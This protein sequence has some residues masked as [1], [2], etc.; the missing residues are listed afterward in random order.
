[1]I[2]FYLLSLMAAIGC[3]VLIDRRYKLAFFYD[4]RCTAYTLGTSIV[5]FIVWDLLGIHLDIFYRGASDVLL[6]FNL[7]PNFPLEEIFFLFLLTYVTLIV[8]RLL[9]KREQ[10]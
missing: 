8:Y 9:K 7:L 6:P 1:M 4:V 10:S 2:P 5:L 3:L